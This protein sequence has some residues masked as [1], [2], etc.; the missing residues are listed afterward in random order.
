MRQVTINLY[1]F[2]ELN[3][4]TK[5]KVLENF[6]YLNTEW[7]WYESV[8]EGFEEIAS[9]YGIEVEDMRFS[10]FYSQGDGASFEGEIV[11]FKKFAEKTGLKRLVRLSDSIEYNLN[12]LVKRV[13]YHYYHSKTVEADIRDG[14]YYPRLS[15][16]IEE[17]LEK[18]KEELCEKLYRNLE[19]EYDYLTSDEVVADTIR[20][21]EYEFTEGGELF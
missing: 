9:E 12:M 21:N 18:V 8:Y 19:E 3:E 6:R 14:G 2:D 16:L 17:K 20:A 10:G 11:D 15:N 4:E 7:D 13:T 5:K 1:K